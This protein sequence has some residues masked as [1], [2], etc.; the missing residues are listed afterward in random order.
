MERFAKR[1]DQNIQIVLSAYSLN[2]M[3]RDILY[4]KGLVEIAPV[5]WGIYQPKDVSVRPY[6]HFLKGVGQGPIVQVKGLQD[7]EEL[8]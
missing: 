1:A 5:S 2:H 4:L 8:Y 7:N 6:E 3:V